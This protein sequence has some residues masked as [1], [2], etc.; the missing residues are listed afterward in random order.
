MTLFEFIKSIARLPI[1]KAFA[2]IKNHQD[3]SDHLKSEAPH[4]LQPE[5]KTFTLYSDDFI[6]KNGDVISYTAQEDPKNHQPLPNGFWDYYLSSKR[7]WYR[8]EVEEEAFVFHDT[9][10]DHREVK[11]KFAKHG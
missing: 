10:K 2:S 4:F 6:F 7:L 1:D 9:S 8:Y 3:Y 11:P 5:G